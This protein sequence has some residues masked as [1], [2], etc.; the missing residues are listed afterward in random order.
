MEKGSIFYAYV[1]TVV[2]VFLELC[3]Q[4]EIRLAADPF[5][6]HV[7]QLSDTG[8]I[9]EVI[10]VL[11]HGD[12]SFAVVDAGVLDDSTV[13]IVLLQRRE[14]RRQGVES[15]EPFPLMNANKPRSF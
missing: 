7:I 1:G 10:Q 2:E 12:V 3:A 14:S 15:K 6:R 5:L 9:V 8:I 11:R 13:L 4:G